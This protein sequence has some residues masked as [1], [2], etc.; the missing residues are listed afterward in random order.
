VSY[1]LAL[2][3]LFALLLLAGVAYQATGTAR[4]RRRFPPPGRMVD[5]GGHRLHIFISGEEHAGTGPTVILESGVAAA[6][7]SWKV[8]QAE[9]AKFARVASYDRAGLAWSDPGPRPRTPERILADLRALL[10]GAQ[11]GPPYVLVGHSFGGLVAQLYAARH[12]DE[13][14][15]LVLLDPPHHSEWSPAMPPGKRRMF[16]RGVGLARRGARIARVG[17][18]RFFLTLLGFG[19]ARGPRMFARFVSGEGAGVASRM[20][21]EVKKLPP[22]L[23]PV[24]RALWSQPK[25]FTAM[26]DHLEALPE[27]SVAVSEIRSLGDMPLIVLT[28]SGPSPERRHHQD[29]VAALSSR[30]Q[31]LIAARSGHWV[32]LDQPELVVQ[33]VRQCLTAGRE[34]TRGGLT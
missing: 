29:Q 28:A 19:L 16:R 24:L 4:D 31:H 32:Q 17:L 14:V 2:A 13:V 8:V 33:V 30:G 26:A 21:G 18:T 22:E 11:L 27:V 1:L 9:I 15:G 6:S 10:A 25:C 20:V 23:R 3:L 34:P 7:P 12:G 5:V